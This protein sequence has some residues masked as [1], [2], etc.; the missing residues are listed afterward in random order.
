MSVEVALRHR[1]AGFAVQ[2][3]FVIATGS[4][5]ALFGPSGAGKSTI[6]SAIAGLLRPDQGRIVIGGRV[7]LDTGARIAVAAQHRHIG[8]V[9]QNARLFPH[10]TVEDN[11]RY[12]WRRAATRLG[13]AEIAHLVDLL[14]LSLLR[15]RR[16]AGLSGGE[17]ARVA[18]GRALLC[19]PQLLLLDEPLAGLDAARKAEILPYLERLRDVVGLPILYVSHALDEV[20]RLADSVVLLRDGVVRAQGSVFDLLGDLHF[21][22]GLG[23]S[24]YGAV[25]AAR[26]TTHHDDG[27]SELAFAGGRLLVERLGRPIGSRLRLR[28]RAEDVMLALHEPHAISANNVLT[29]VV[30]AI[31]VH[32]ALADVQLQCG[33]VK[34]VA[35]I[36]TASQMRLSLRPGMTVFAIIKAVTIDPKIV[37]LTM[38]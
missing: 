32:G 36:T 33:A 2:A 6:V 27:L 24:A 8:V 17:K 3:E 29:A 20:T 12:G 5:T 1:F 11:L 10:L 34:L 35:R 26:I 30:S 38:D 16:P 37:P 28:I 13:E 9:F 21:A 25:I 18:L 31:E 15:Q 4:V 14:G 23:G 19:A 7:V 22:A